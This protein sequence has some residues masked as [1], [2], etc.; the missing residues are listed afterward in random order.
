M[1]NGFEMTI[2]PRKATLI[3]GILVLLL[4]LYF[5]LIISPLP[6][7]EKAELSPV[8]S[9]A[10][11]KVVTPTVS[12]QNRQSARVIK[13]IDGDTV[14]IDMDKKTWSVRLIGLD[15]PEAHDPRKPVQCFA[16]EATNRLKDILDGKMIFLEADSTQGDKDK[17]NRLLRY[18][19]LEDGTNINELM[20]SEGFAHEYTY[21][22]PYKYRDDFKQAEIEARESKRGLWA[23]G[24]CTDGSEA[25]SVLP[26]A[27]SS[28]EIE[29]NYSCGA[30][31]KCSEMKTCAEAKFYLNTCGLSRLDGD[32]DG[33]PCESLCR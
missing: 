21:N 18:L 25:N 11:I 9:G 20:L 12:P 31:S 30:K 24:A 26:A 4:F 5:A 22:L 32:K 17:Y 6:N 33:T 16:K 1:Y 28:L 27:T 2:N 19:F 3:L 29:G 7:K 13:T 8:P 14:N 23:D 15:A 10:D